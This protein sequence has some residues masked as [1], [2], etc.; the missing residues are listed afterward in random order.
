MFSSLAYNWTAVKGRSAG[1]TTLILLGAIL[2]SLLMAGCGG[3]KAENDFSQYEDHSAVLAQV[4]DGQVTAKYYENRLA[5]LKA[6]ELPTKDGVLLDTATEEGKLAFME[7]L[8]NKE[9]MNQ[10][11]I[12]MGYNMDPQVASAR[13]NMLQ[14]EGGLAMWNDVVVEVSSAISEEELQDFYA[15][16]GTEYLCNY[17][18][19][20]LEADAL[21]AREYA[22]SGADW[23]DVVNKFHDG[24]RAVT[25]KYELNVPFG[26]YST[27]FEDS[28]FATELDGVSQPILSSYGYWV[29]RVVEINQNKKPNLEKAKAKIL[30]ITRNRKIGNLREAFKE[31]MRAKY[32]FLI[33][34]DALWAVYKGMPEGGIMDPE[35]NEPFKREQLKNLELS[36]ENLSMVFYSYTGKDGESVESTVADYK[37]HFDKMSIFQRPKKEEMLGGLRRKIEDEIERGIMNIEAEKRGYFERPD[38]VAKVD[39]KIEEI[40]VTR[41][42]KEAVAYDDVVTPEQLDAFWAEFESDYFSPETRNG[43]LVICLNRAK[44]DEAF[45]AATNGEAWRKILVDFGSDPGNKQRGGKTEFVAADSPT[46]MAAPFFSLEN[47][48]DISQPFAVDQGRYALVMLE[49]IKPA[50]QYKLHEVSEAIGGRIKNERQEAAFVS[51]LAQWESEIGVEI[52]TEKLADLKSWE[53]LT[54]VVVP[55]NLVPRN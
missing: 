37:T 27:K 52:F 45:A 9:L 48:G 21:K 14:Y 29:V 32:N 35:T 51:T 40:M 12:R 49:S 6:E 8:V 20:D 46:A 42:Y 22:L 31:E 13:L 50:K 19:C 16:M 7:S 30:D 41:L 53:E 15:Q 54:K 55:D 26:Q 2:V 17:V 25:N 4:G 18:I 34:Q 38:I 33:N 44:A 3:D 24:S 1:T 36:T 5:M 28:I 10:K 43:R 39:K 23:E 47:S 11:A